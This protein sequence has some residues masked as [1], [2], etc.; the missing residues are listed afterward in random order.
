MLPKIQALDI[1][2]DE[3][4]NHLIEKY[5]EIRWFYFLLAPF[6]L[7]IQISAGA[8]CLFLGSY[9]FSPM[10]GYSYPQWWRIAL[11]SQFVLL[12]F[13][14]L[15]CVISLYCGEGTA[16]IFSRYSS[17]I[18]LAGND[19]SPLLKIP[20]ISINIIDLTHWTV[21][22]ILVGKLIKTNFVKSFS[23]VLRTYGIGYLFYNALAM[24]LVLYLS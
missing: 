10:N 18:C 12:G 5:L 15:L 14:G 21:M 23:Y 22:S 19:I 20:L 11:L 2:G 17:L 8:L 9:F 4:K 24:F 3:T 16:A 13:N 6:L 1:I 7:V